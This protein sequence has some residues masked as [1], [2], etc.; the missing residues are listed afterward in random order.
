MSSRRHTSAALALAAS[1]VLALALCARAGAEE[2]ALPVEVRL[3]DLFR[4]LRERS[5]RTQSE[6]TG[7]DLAKADALE[8]SLLPNPT[9][10]YGNVSKLSGAN[11]IDGTNHQVTVGMPLLLLGQRGAHEEAANKHLDAAHEDAD[12][13]YAELALRTRELFI[14]VLTARETVRSLAETQSEL[15]RAA[16]IASARQQS[17]LARRYDVVKVSIEKNANGARLADANADLAAATGEL[18]TWLGFPDWRPVVVGELQ[19]LDLQPDLDALW[20]QAESA[21]P[22]LRAARANEDAA[23]ASQDSVKLD[24]WPVPVATL[25]T[26]ITT[27]QSSTNGLAG[28]SVDLPVFDRGQGKLAHADAELLG[29]QR[30]RALAFAAARAELERDV[31]VLAGRHAALASFES[32]VAGELPELR[33]MAED[34]YRSGQGGIIDLIDAVRSRSDLRLERIE[35]VHEVMAAEAAALAASGRADALAP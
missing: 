9:L 30:E 3:E 20:H 21:N 28:I 25:G 27:N 33:Q 6:L 24:R 1:A 14:D 8:A 18:A 34:A 15:D 22:A 10:S 2:P 17:G 4:L 23:R 13:R 26:L 7:V 19:P 32:N 31:Q 16:E 29:A 35:L 11:T 12:S 5:P